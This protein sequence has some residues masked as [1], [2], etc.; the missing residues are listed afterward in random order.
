MS[1]VVCI[2]LNIYSPYKCNS[3]L[4]IIWRTNLRLNFSEVCK[5]KVYIFLQTFDL[6]EVLFYT[7]SEKRNAAQ[8]N[9]CS[10]KLSIFMG[11]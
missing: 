8:F 3:E 1:C 2:L 11:F 4:C 7:I 6:S 5:G 9:L 10:S